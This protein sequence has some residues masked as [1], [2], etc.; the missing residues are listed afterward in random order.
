[1]RHF[2]QLWSS[3]GNTLVYIL[4]TK[5]QDVRF[6]LGLF[7]IHVPRPGVACEG[8]NVAVLFEWRRCLFKN[9]DER[10]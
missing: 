8:I 6:V 5:E 3:G 9:D 2:S 7:K 10:T 1:M 4:R